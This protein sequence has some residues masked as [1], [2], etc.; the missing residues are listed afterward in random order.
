MIFGVN[1]GKGLIEMHHLK[2]KF[3]YRFLEKRELTVFLVSVIQYCLNN[4]LTIRPT[5]HVLVIYSI[6][7]EQFCMYSAVVD[8][9]D[10]VENKTDRN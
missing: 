10:L 2:A 7:I 5:I 8:I 3:P 4:N 1:K 6:N 9:I